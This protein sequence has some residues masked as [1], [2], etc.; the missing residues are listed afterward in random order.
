MKRKP[1]L[2]RRLALAVLALVLIG[3]LAAHGGGAPA[4]KHIEP[5]LKETP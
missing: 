3:G 5:A 1:L 4:S 2:S